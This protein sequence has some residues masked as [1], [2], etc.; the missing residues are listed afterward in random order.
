MFPSFSNFIEFTRTGS[1]QLIKNLPPPPFP[2]KKKLKTN[3]RPFPQL[4]NPPLL[5]GR[6][7]LSHLKKRL[8]SN[9]PSCP[10]PPISVSLPPIKPSRVVIGF[11]SDRTCPDKRFPP[12]GR[13]VYLLSVVCP[14]AIRARP[15]T[16]VA[17][18]L[19]SL[20]PRPNPR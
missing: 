3:H 7:R 18:S 8:P 1:V 20:S 17:F 10:P 15:S 6:K 9:P 13:T 19:P 2:K 4:D 14:R 5:E 16:D 11:S 12:Y